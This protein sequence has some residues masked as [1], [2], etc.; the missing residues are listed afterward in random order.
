[1]KI[2]ECLGDTYSIGDGRNRLRW[3]WH[4][5]KRPINFVLRKVNKIERNQTT[6]G[7]HKKTI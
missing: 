2:L 6:R 4:V 1:M 7:R 5:E 3:F